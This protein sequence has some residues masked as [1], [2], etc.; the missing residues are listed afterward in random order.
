MSASH[1]VKSPSCFEG[2]NPSTLT[3][4]SRIGNPQDNCFASFACR[5]INSINRLLMR[6]YGFDGPCCKSW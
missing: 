1:I 2:K 4:L 5:A 6:A 3:M